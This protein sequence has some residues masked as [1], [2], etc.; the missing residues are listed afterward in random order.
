M[1]RLGID[2][3]ATHR[4]SDNGSEYIG[5][6]NAKAPSSYTLAIESIKGQ[7]HTTIFPGAHRMQ[8]DVET[9]HNLIETEFFEIESF[10]SRADFFNKAYSYQLFFNLL[11]PNSYKENKTPWQLI[12]EKDPN[13]HVNVAKIPVVDLD[14]LLDLYLA[15]HNLFCYH[16]GPFPIGLNG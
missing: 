15:N 3:S 7:T 4:Q 10:S 8:A 11:R 13:I 1:S 2:L 6:W 12:Q 5:S 9:I 14:A 16:R